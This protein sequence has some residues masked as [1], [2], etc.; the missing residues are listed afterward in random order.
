MIT[1]KEIDYGIAC[2]IG[3]TIYLN[4]DLKEDPLLYIK[5]I[6]HEF[7]HSPGFNKQDILLDVQNPQLKGLKFRYY[8]WIL[9]HPKALAEL[10]PISKYDGQIVWNPLLT[11]M[12]A[13][14]LAIGGLLW[15]TLG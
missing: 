4:K 10:L 2:R 1:I 8:K 9:K 11:V 15:I 14:C 6:E 13:I 3:N 12:W 5:I 7:C